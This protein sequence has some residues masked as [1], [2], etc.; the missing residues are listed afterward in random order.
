MCL[1]PFGFPFALA[2]IFGATGSIEFD[3]GSR[4]SDVLRLKRASEMRQGG[5]AAKV[6]HSSPEQSEEC[7]IA[8]TVRIAHQVFQHS[9]I[10]QE[11]YRTPHASYSP[12]TPGCFRWPQA[13]RMQELEEARRQ[14]YQAGLVF[15]PIFQHPGR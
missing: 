10:H 7:N 1:G 9:Q 4:G 8:C 5:F 13:A 12:K 15:G 2:E 6:E 11:L 3:F 14:A